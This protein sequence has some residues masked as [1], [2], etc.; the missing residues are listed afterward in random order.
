[1]PLFPPRDRRPHLGDPLARH[2]GPAL[3][4]SLAPPQGPIG[5]MEPTSSAVTGGLATSFPLALEAAP[6]SSALGQQI[7]GFVSGHRLGLPLGH[8]QLD[9]LEIHRREL[10]S[11]SEGTRR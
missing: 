9:K 2:V 6:K 11:R 7:A 5:S 3:A 10:L 1:M 4:A 8:H